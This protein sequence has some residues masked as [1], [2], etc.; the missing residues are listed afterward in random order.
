MLHRS[1]LRT[2]QQVPGLTELRCGDLEFLSRRIWEADAKP[3]IV[4]N[5]QGDGGTPPPTFSDSNLPLIRF[6][7]RIDALIHGVM[8]ILALI[9][10]LCVP[11]VLSFDYIYPLRQAQIVEITEMSITLLYV[12]GML[13]RLRTSYV[14]PNE[15]T[16]VTEASAIW[17]HTVN[18][19]TWTLD[20]MGLLSTPFL[21]FTGPG[22]YIC[23]GRLVKCWRLAD[24]RHRTMLLP[25]TTSMGYQLFKIL[26]G[27][28]IFNHLYACL[29]FWAKVNSPVG[30]G[31]E[32][33]AWNGWSTD[34]FSD[35]QNSDVG[36]YSLPIEPGGVD[37]LWLCY[38]RA[39]KDGM[40]LIVTYGAPNAVSPVELL[41]INILG[42]LSGCITAYH[43]GM[44]VTQINRASIQESR[45]AEQA[46]VLRTAC[47]Y[48]GVPEDLHHRIRQYHSYLAVHNISDAQELFSQLSSNLVLETRVYRMRNIIT[49]NT[50][51][52]ELSSRMI[53]LLVS[54]CIDHV[55]SPGDYVVRKGEI[56][57]CMYIV[58]RGSLAVL[59][60]ETPQKVVARIYSGDTFGEAC[61]L[62]G[63]M[64]R[65]AWIRSESFTVLSRLDKDQ[66]ETVLQDHGDLQEGVLNAIRKTIEGFKKPDDKRKASIAEDEAQV[67]ENE[68]EAIDEAIEETEITPLMS[69]R[70]SVAVDA[71]G[72]SGSQVHKPKARSH[73]R[74]TI[75]LNSSGAEYLANSAKLPGFAGRH[76][77][78]LGNAGMM[79]PSMAANARISGHRGPP[80]LDERMAD[81]MVR[82]VNDLWQERE[83]TLMR[84]RGIETA[85]EEI[86]AKLD[87]LLHH[88][89]VGDGGPKSPKGGTSRFQLPFK[90]TPTTH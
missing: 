63:K 1:S 28:F 20:F 73:S 70:S 17:H 55:F 69:Q 59:V 61:F 78:S 38:A 44:V 77:A 76:R 74:P 72:P 75:S 9:D 67:Q 80:L 87:Q 54:T 50:I 8:R 32:W 13:A 19:W 88:A 84:L 4:Q 53:F 16:E 48:M 11:F 5:A 83:P 40:C 62:S 43:Y 57:D 12:S 7:S 90:K 29:W 64:Q 21:Y 49:R 37:D 65:M 25:A 45:Y 51:F 26:L 60:G 18:S 81:T 34:I 89:G 56:G 41:V 33:S 10:L 71:N 36:G 86:K 66:F 14:D 30:S 46:A 82:Q 24:D 31:R 47:L 58:L 68:N 35:T 23:L 42:P 22:G 15:V 39:L 52:Q 85:Q 3:E 27:M 79:R 2:Q 6:G